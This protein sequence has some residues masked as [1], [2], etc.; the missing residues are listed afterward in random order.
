MAALQVA[1]LAALVVWPTRPAAAQGPRLAVFDFELIDTSLQGEVSGPRADEQRRLAMISDQLRQRLTD[2]GYTVVDLSPASDAIRKAQPLYR[3]GGCAAEIAKTLGARFALTGTVQKV[4]ALIL[5]INLA[6]WDA[7]S[8][9]ARFSGSVDIRGND[10]ESWSRGLSYIARN[11]LLPALAK[12]AP[13]SHDG[14][15]PPQNNR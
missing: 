13:I 3:C 12:I 10:A 14:G 6:V 8:G 4:S 11:Q 1:L 5:N 2:A 7:E 9:E 15:A